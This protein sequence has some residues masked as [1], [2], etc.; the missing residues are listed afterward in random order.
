MSSKSETSRKK[1]AKALIE[2]LQ[3]CPF[4]RIT[5]SN[6]T[7]KAGVSRSAFYSNYK[8]IEDILTDAILESLKESFD[9]K[10]MDENYVYSRNFVCD[11][12]DY[13]DKYGKLLL[14]ISK[15]DLLDFITIST[16]KTVDSTLQSY[17]DDPLIQNH[18][19]YFQYFTVANMYFTCLAWLKKGKKET[20]EE[21][22]EICLHFYDISLQK[23]LEQ[24]REQE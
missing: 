4:D 1:L 2:L 10:F 20:K 11:F 24:K 7:E 17:Y 13:F 9:E 12:I 5:V 22:Y 23:R 19:E 16:S 6:L 15:W 3:V 8:R 14:V 18:I 21:L